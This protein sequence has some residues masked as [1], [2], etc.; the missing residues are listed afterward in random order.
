MVRSL[1]ARTDPTH[2]DTVE[3]RLYS[4]FRGPQCHVSPDVTQVVTHIITTEDVTD[5]AT[6]QAVTVVATTEAVLATKA[7]TDT[8]SNEAVT[9]EILA[10]I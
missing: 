1:Q 2:L 5:V 10:H 7:V 9:I 6:T 8:V 4:T 3:V